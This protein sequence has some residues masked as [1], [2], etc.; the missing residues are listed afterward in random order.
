MTT[1]FSRDMDTLTQ[2]GPQATQ[3]EAP[4]ARDFEAPGLVNATGEGQAAA[5]AQRPQYSPVGQPGMIEEIHWHEVRSPPEQPDQAP[6]STGMIGRFHPG[7]RPRVIVI[8]RRRRGKRG[9]RAGPSQ[10]G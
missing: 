3:F 9:K 8:G 5:E 2:D 1:P 7:G 6:A 4:T 10:Q